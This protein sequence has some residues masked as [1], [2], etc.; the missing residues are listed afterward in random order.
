MFLSTNI[1]PWDLLP[2]SFRMIQFPWRF[3]SYVAISV[4]LLAPLCLKYLKGNKK[5]IITFVSIFLM[6][7]IASVSFSTKYDISLDD[8]DCINSNFTDYNAGMG[9]QKEYLPSN[10]FYNMDYYNNRSKDIIIKLGSGEVNI[11]NIKTLIN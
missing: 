11:I 3:E 5:I 6:V 7:G 9:W 10:T 2:Q 8:S 4:S 1:F